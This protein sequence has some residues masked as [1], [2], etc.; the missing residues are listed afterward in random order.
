MAKKRN[1]LSGVKPT[2]FRLPEDYLLRL[3]RIRKRES[4]R[5]G[6]RISRTDVIRKL[7]DCEDGVFLESREKEKLPEEK[8]KRMPAP[9]MPER[10]VDLQKERIGIYD[11]QGRPVNE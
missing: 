7:I 11:K 3:D 1:K 2:S 6:W 5:T 8:P 10:D 4:L 9:E